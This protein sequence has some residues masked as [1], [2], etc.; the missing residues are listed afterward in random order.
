MRLKQFIFFASLATLPGCVPPPP[1]NAHP[2]VSVTNNGS[3][4]TITKTLTVASDQ[5]IRLGFLHVKQNPDCSL[6]ET[7]KPVLSIASQPAHGT[8]TQQQMQDFPIYPANNPMSKCNQLRIPGTAISYT[9]QLG[10]SG[11]DALSYQVFVS[12]GHEFIFNDNVTVVPQPA[13]G[14]GQIAPSPSI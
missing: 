4:V 13:S 7:Q 10:Y 11:P 8:V 12:D 2:T 6:D 14:A 9:P 1:P 3:V 5:T